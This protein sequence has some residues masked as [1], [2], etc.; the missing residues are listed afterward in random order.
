MYCAIMGLR[1]IRLGRFI[2]NEACINNLGSFFF[3]FVLCAQFEVF[4][5]DYGVLSSKLQAY[6]ELGLSQSS[7]ILQ[8]G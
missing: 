7:I 2:N 5:Y 3:F 6:E 1:V 4:L 8:G